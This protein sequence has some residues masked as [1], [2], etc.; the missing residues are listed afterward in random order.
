MQCS[1]LPLLVAELLVLLILL[2]HLWLQGLHL[3]L[4]P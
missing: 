3:S 4:K 1:L 2:L